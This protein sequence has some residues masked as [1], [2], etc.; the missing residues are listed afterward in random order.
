MPG[1]FVPV[2]PEPATDEVKLICDKVSS[3]FVNIISLALGALSDL[4][5]P[6]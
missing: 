4:Y 2:E 3:A 5:T 1:G 6:Y